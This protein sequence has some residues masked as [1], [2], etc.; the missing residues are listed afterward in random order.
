MLLYLLLALAEF[1][2]NGAAKLRVADVREAVQAMPAGSEV[3]G[4]RQLRIAFPGKSAANKSS[5]T[6]TLRSHRFT[7]HELAHRRGASL[8]DELDG[9]RVLILGVDAAGHI[10]Y[11]QTQPDPRVIRGEFTG[12]SGLIEGRAVEN[13]HAE[14]LLDLP[15]DP[16][17]T[18]VRIYEQKSDELSLLGAIALP[19][20]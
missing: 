16:R 2:V 5:A 3:A 15:N 1:S 12:P 11:W 14:M 10:R 19:A 7:D 17:I 8:A 20:R 9:G 18:V 4:A 13:P 6:L